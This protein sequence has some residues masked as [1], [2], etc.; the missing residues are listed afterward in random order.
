[1]TPERWQKIDQLL[2]EALDLEPRERVAFLDGACVDDSQLRREV[3]SLLASSERAGNFIEPVPSSDET[4]EG[5]SPLAGQALGSYRLLH[6]IGRGGMG[7]VYLAVRADD[8]FQK[9]VAIK[10]VQASPRD[11]DLLRRFRRER[12]ILANL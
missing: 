8:E 9:Q 11:K 1:M 4:T 12:Q 7:V 10:L 5:D 3:E 6:E 2:D